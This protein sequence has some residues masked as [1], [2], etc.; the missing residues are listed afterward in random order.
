[1]AIA[2]RRFLIVASRV[3]A[4]LPPRDGGLAGGGGAK[5]ILPSPSQSFNSAHTLSR[6][7]LQM[8]KFQSQKKNTCGDTERIVISVPKGTSWK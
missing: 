8:T 7:Q 6:F 4:S 5:W 3:D 1:M 2:T